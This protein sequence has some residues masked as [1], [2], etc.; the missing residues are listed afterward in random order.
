MT[1]DSIEDDA[2]NITNNSSSDD[3]S[4]KIARQRTEI[5]F[6]YADL[7]DSVQVAEIIRNQYGG[8]CSADQ[9]AAVLNQSITSGAFRSKIGAA[10]TYGLLHPKR[11]DLET[12]ELAN[13]ILTPDT[14][15]DA[16]V[17]AFLGVP[18]FQKL[19]EAYL[20]QTLPAD[21]GIEAK[22]RQL[23]VPVKGTRF[24]R[25]VFQ[26]AAK[27]AGFFDAADNRLVKPPVGR[28]AVDPS[29]TP[30]E[31]ELQ[32]NTDDGSSDDKDGV[33]DREDWIDMKPKLVGELFRELPDDGEQFAS[34]DR[35]QWES[36]LKA[37][38]DLVYKTSKKPAGELTRGST[39]IGA[40]IVQE[41]ES[42]PVS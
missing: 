42:V 27:Q 35:V 19:Y 9:L 25:S 38:L 28:I 39:E 14:S 11:G 37:I 12:T 17:E 34:G 36:A 21:A 18:L 26:R 8:T 13:R 10:R 7:D 2:Q 4:Q 40:Q 31:S 29:N 1:V 41:E 32:R 23:G 5:A 16:K 33:I 6:P 3:T 30:D 20:G 15:S 24:A 22:M